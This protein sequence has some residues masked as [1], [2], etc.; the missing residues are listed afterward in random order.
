MT[1]KINIFK[2]INYVFF[3]IVFLSGCSS[4]NSIVPDFAVFSSVDENVDLKASANFGDNKNKLPQVKQYEKQNS[5]LDGITNN[6]NVLNSKSYNLTNSTIQFPLEE[7]WE[8]DTDQ[9]LGSNTPLFS[10]PISIFSKIYLINSNGNL[11]KIDSKNGNIMWN[12]EIFKNLENSIIGAPA[13]SG[14]YI[15]Q[16][17]VTIFTHSGNNELSSIDGIS[18]SIIW[19]KKYKLPFRGGIT[20][21][22]DR[23]YVSDYQ[24]NLFSINSSNGK[25]IWKT[26]LGTDYN[27]VYTNARPIV[28][29]DKIIVPGT[30]GSF[31]VL[32]S[33]TGDV[34]W[35][36]NISSTSRLSKIFHTGDIVANPIY[37][38]GIIYL[39][40][41]SGFT[42]AFDIET[43]EKLWTFPVGGLETPVLSGKTI[44]VNGNMG[45]LVALD[46]ITGQLRWEK[47]FESHVNIDSYFSTETI[48]IYKG[49]VLTDS[50]L[51]LSDHYGTIRI[52]DANTG[53]ELDNLSIGKL[54]LAPIPV[55]NI[56]LF[57]RVDG[58]LLAYE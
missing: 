27:S 58:N 37:H 17:D 15:S 50:K 14:N 8:V 21:F 22:Q 6:L 11:L 57:L 42:V 31:F 55:N 30:G 9:N 32:S 25:V 49:P 13:I 51:L 33:K 47:K 2:I 54:A 19:E 4:Y 10:E 39:V 40:S 20:S 36:E 45:H 7:L 24:G 5:E 52:L 1:R 35:T 48:A 53:V 56:V 28:I 34:I 41:Q 29:K 3:N 46:R 18:G 43:E 16:N 44:F 26:S 38:Q 23:F 12:K